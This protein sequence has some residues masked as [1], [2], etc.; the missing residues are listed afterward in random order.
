MKRIEI[1]YGIVDN[2][3]RILL[4][5]EYDPHTIALVK[6]IPGARWN[7]GMKCWH[8]AKVNGPADKLNYRFREKLLFVPRKIPSVPGPENEPKM[9]DLPVGLP[10]EFVK[11]MKLKDFSIKTIKTYSSMLRLFMNFYK[12][13]PL[14]DLTDVDIREYLLYLVDEK[15]VSQSYQNQ[16]IN[17]I[18]F[19]YEQVL[20]RPTKTY[21]LQRPKHESKLPSVLSEEE[22]LRLLKQVGN[23]KHKAALSLIYSAGLRVGE[24]INLKLND[25]DS[26]R[27][28][29]R[30]RQGKGKKD[31]VSVLSPNILRLLRDYYKEYRPKVWAFEGQFGGQYSAGSVQAVFRK[32]KEDAGIMKN[33][34]VHTLRHSFATH[35]LERGTNLRYIQELLGHQSSRTTEIYTHVTN[36]GFKNIISPFDNLN[37]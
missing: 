17:A 13:R 8:I 18:K 5:F 2:I 37:L 21:Y 20:G 16:A 6:S 14:D 29:I 33:A 26:S 22:V 23:L 34:T 35:L 1:E 30:I 36:K 28:Q 4:Y 24:L 7:P 10:E 3:Q 31:R 11:T 25:I 9:A 27:K 32:A 15:K 19:Y 12:E